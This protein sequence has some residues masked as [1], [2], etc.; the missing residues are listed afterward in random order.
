MQPMAGKTNYKIE[1]RCSK[2]GKML[3]RT[4][5]NTE[6][7]CPRCGAVNALESETG[8]VRFV[9]GMEGRTTA[10]GIQF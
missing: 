3:A 10:S 1:F 2:C 6:I 8:K 9:D 7:K 4:D 5:G